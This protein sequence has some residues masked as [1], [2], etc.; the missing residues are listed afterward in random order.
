MSVAIIVVLSI[1][2]LYLAK[3]WSDSNVERGAL[4]DQ[5]ASLKRQLTKRVRP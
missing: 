4:R 5:V 1:V 3:G 2:A